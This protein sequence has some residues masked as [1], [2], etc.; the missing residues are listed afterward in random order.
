VEAVWLVDVAEEAK[1]VR[2]NFFWKR[3]LCWSCLSY[4]CFS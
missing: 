4:V 1:P 2:L 3:T